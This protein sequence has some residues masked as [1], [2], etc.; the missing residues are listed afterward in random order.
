M[1]Q[2][3]I[4]PF[5]G[6]SLLS[7][8]APRIHA[9]EKITAA[10]EFGR[11]CGIGRGLCSIEELSDKIDDDSEEQNFLYLDGVSRV[12][13]KIMK[14]SLCRE[15][16][17]QEFKN[18]HMYTVEEDFQLLREKKMEKPL[19]IARGAHP[20]VE[21]EECYIISFTIKNNQ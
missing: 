7:L 8:T 15:M 1:K 2:I 6:I 17:E 10:V 20:I 21:M 9:Q 16:E 4:T 13:L 14:N 12:N 5:F 18:Q 19:L 3:L 11:P